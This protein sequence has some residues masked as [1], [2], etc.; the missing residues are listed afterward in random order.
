MM[1]SQRVAVRSA[2]KI[3]AAK[4]FLQPELAGDP[5]Q[6]A[7]PLPPAAPVSISGSAI[8]ASDLQSAEVAV[9]SLMFSRRAAALVAA[10]PGLRAVEPAESFQSYLRSPIYSPK[11]NGP[12]IRLAG[13]RPRRVDHRAWQTDFKV[14]Q[15][16]RGTC[17]AF[18]GTAALE[19]A[20]MRKGIRVKLSEQYLFH[21]SKSHENQVAGRGIHS[22]IG[23]EGGPDI[24]RHMKYWSSPLYEHAPYADQPALQSL[25]NSI[26][27]TGLGLRSAA[28]GTL[29]Q[30]DWFEF[31]LRHIPLTARWFAQYSVADFGVLSN[32]TLDDLKN[33]LA[34]GYDVVIFV[35]GHAMLC[36]GYD[37]DQGVLLIKNSQS[38][39]GFETMRYTG[40]P[41]FTLVTNAAY[42]VKSVRRPQTQW[43]AMWLGRW[44]TDHDGWRGR[45]VLRRYLDIRSDRGIPPPSRPIAL[46]TWYGMDGRTL[47]VVGGFVDDGRGLHCKVGEQPFEVY[48]HTR[49]PYRAAGRCGWNGAWF[50]VVMSRGTA[51]GAG[52]NFDR[53]ETIG[54]WDTEHDGRFGQVRI[55]ASPRY[56]E[57][58]DGAVRRAWIDQA[59]IKHQVDLHVDFGAGNVDQHYQ[60]LHHTG[61]DGLMG[62]VT[63]WAGKDWPVQARMASHLYL[64]RANGTL[65]WY[66]HVG[67]CQRTFEWD[68]SAQVGVG[69]QGFQRVF[70]GGDGVI[71][72]IRPDG[73]LL[74]YHHEGRNQG[75]S[76]WAGPKEVGSG[77]AG[78]SQVFAGDGGV[79]YAVRPDGSLVWYRHLGRRDGSFE[80]QGPFDVGVGWNMFNALC[81]GPDG[82]LYGK[83][84]DGRLL[85]YRHYGHDHGYGIWHG[86]LPVG[87]GWQDYSRI[88]AV[89]NGFVYGRN[90]KGELWLW[91]HHGFQTG[92][93]DWAPGALV[94]TGWGGSDVL[95][96][97]VA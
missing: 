3:V 1:V 27:G 42:Y 20:Y 11:V 6:G 30:A 9:D 62:G 40:D 84:P 82:T 5:Q 34:A 24:V 79:I 68:P 61:E 66:R 58:A 69:W 35:P 53:S 52:G 97:I 29:E 36:Y 80:W 87:V 76:Q 60:L 12:V 96:V 71:Y 73:K 16:Q 31:D 41:R 83:T 50:G 18:A 72:A 49:D 8:A 46:G 90:A 38:L 47:P 15:G 89:G 92:Q 91:R 74:W 21:V 33:T 2:V 77:W 59:P 25:A 39:P 10:D 93:N 26:P 56:Q 28:G 55:G 32:Y 7:V 13:V 44:E 48:L 63:Q 70:G 22:L 17:W 19:A 23:F 45:M 57:A 51:V 81:A 78:F 4:P 43:A 37:D 14:S 94:G 65:H 88:W 67:R 75:S 64:L 85:W 54:L 95:D 86:P